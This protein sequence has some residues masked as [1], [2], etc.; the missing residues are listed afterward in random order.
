MRPLPVA[1]YGLVLLMAGTAYQLIELA[2]GAVEGPDST[3]AE[4]VG[5]HAKEWISIMGYLA[6]MVL[7]WVSPLISIALFVFVAASWLVPDKRFER[8][9]KQ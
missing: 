2:L 5:G 8:R 4:A 7:A 6:G 1:S 9:L 3:V